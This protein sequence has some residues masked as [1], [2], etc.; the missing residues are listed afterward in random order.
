MI[1]TLMYGVI[2]IAN[3]D[4]E[5]HHNETALEVVHYEGIIFPIISSVHRGWYVLLQY[6]YNVAYI[7]IQFWYLAASYSGGKE[8]N[9]LE[10]QVH[11]ETALFCAIDFWRA[12]KGSCI[13][14]CTYSKEKEPSILNSLTHDGEE[15][16]WIVSPSK[17]YFCIS[18][19]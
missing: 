12:V 14:S 9:G 5:I 10:K 17:T 1:Y 2:E 4:L 3:F 15:F 13:K 11:H 6:W 8:H 19:S 18:W 16:G 7:V